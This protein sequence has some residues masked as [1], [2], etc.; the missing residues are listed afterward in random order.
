MLQAAEGCFV[1]STGSYSGVW[2]LALDLYSRVERR[3]LVEGKSEYLQGCNPQFIR[4]VRAAITPEDRRLPWIHLVWPFQA[5]LASAF[6]HHSDQ[7][8]ETLS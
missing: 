7:H 2:G 8:H 5:E 1:G 4:S 6:F 3:R